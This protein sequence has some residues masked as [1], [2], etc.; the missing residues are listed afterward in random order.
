MKSIYFDVS[1]PKILATKALA[2]AL[3]FIYYT[4]L[5]PVGFSDIPEQEL[6]GKNWVRVKSLATGICGADI[7]MFFVKASPGISIAALPGVPRAFMGHEVVG[8]VIEKGP[9]VTALAIGDRVILERYLPCCSTKEIAPPCGPCKEGNYTLCENFSEGTLPP[10]LG[11]GFSERFLAHKTQ[12]VKVPK[13][14]TDDQAVL[15]E[16]TAVSLHAVLSRLPK[17]G[18][19]VLVIGAG[20]IG[21][22]VIQIAKALG[23]DFTLYALEKIPFKKELAKKYGADHVLEGDP[24]RAVAEA[25]GAKLYRGPLGN[26]TTL[27][28][29]DLIYDCVGYSATIHDSLRWLK[30]KGEY[31]MIGNQL[32]PVSF[33]QTPVWQQELTI[34]G[35]NAHGSE[36][37]QGKKTSSFALAMDLIGKKKISVDGLITH[38]FPFADYKQA[39]KLAKEKSS[40]VIKVMLK[41]S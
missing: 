26:N 40:D 8:T 24:Y 6:P 5:S 17:R 30:A 27:G 36:T 28:G 31:I 18:E 3:P 25:T 13:D 29:F 4:P 16:P 41:I 11:A 37:Y 20:T 14:I 39:F 2:P 38:R 33:D 34:K 22:G 7:A 32:S 12:L 23:K 15:V 19:K 21:L 10:N 35:I 9:G 1:V